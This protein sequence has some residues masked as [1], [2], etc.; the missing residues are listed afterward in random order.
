MI[1]ILLSVLVMISALLTV[2]AESYVGWG[3]GNMMQARAALCDALEKEIRERSA[4]L[5]TETGQPSAVEFEYPPGDEKAK[6]RFAE[7][8]AAKKYQDRDV[9]GR[10]ADLLRISNDFSK[11]EAEARPKWLEKMKDKIAA[12]RVEKEGT[13]YGAKIKA[14]RLGAILD[15]SPSM[16]K[17]LPGL[18]KQ[19]SHTFEDYPNVE[20]WGSFF[21]RFKRSTLGGNEVS[22][23]SVSKLH[24]RTNVPGPDEDPWIDTRWYGMKPGDGEDPFDPA[25]HFPANFD[26]PKE[27]R[28]M[29]ATLT[30]RDNVSAILGMVELHKVDALYWFCDLRDRMNQEA[31]Q[32]VSDVILRNKVAFYIHTVGKRPQPELERLVRA[33][34]GKVIT[35]KPDVVPADKTSAK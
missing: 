14:R 15:N 10:W 11:K 33:S 16:T 22:E 17:F 23:D 32:R 30:A 4:R 27:Q 21:N 7:L 24:P 6:R 1:R 13:I 25:W 3:K 28:H 5:G 34:G 18:R 31:L 12:E 35:E 26:V 19:I 9:E 2:K 8:W 29:Y 20:I